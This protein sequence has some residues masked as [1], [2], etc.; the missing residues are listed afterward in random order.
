MAEIEVM[1]IKPQLKL[2]LKFRKIDLMKS[3]KYSKLFK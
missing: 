1:I 3:M 2:I